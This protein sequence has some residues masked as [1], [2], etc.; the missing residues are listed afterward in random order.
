MASDWEVE[1]EKKRPLSRIRTLR[2]GKTNST[3]YIIKV[4]SIKARRPEICRH[5]QRTQVGKSREIG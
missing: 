3:L 1:K 5:H 4:Q 2:E